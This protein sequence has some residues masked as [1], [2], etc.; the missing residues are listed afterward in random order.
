MNASKN[1][2]LL[3]ICCVGCGAYVAEVLKEDHDVTLY[4]Y[5]PSIWP[6]SEYELRRREALNIS[7]D[8]DLPL[9]EGDYVHKAWLAKVKGLEQ[10]PEKG[11]RCHVC[12]E[13]RLRATAAK[14]T[15]LNIE[16]FTT[17]LTVSPHKDAAKIFELGEKIAAEFGLKCIARDF[18]KK[19][20]F[21][22]ACDLSHE[23]GLYRQDYCGCEYS[24]RN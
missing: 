21:K 13:D 3:H 5:N 24:M 7:K 19:D 14:A 2:C 18:K 9:L 12:Y 1:K 8:L 11:R 22:K 4:F 15:E 10:E 6:V 16:Y 23:L 20:G 17:T